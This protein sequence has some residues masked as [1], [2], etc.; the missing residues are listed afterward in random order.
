M[1]L[2]YQRLLLLINHLEYNGH[3]KGFY[4]LKEGELVKFKNNTITNKK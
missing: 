4:N 1:N 3:R 2:D